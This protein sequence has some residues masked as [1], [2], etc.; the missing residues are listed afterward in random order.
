MTRLVKLKVT[1]DIKDQFFF[2]ELEFTT[3]V[4]FLREKKNIE[5]RASYCQN[6]YFKIKVDPSSS[7]P[8]RQIA[9][10][11]RQTFIAGKLQTASYRS[12]YFN[13]SS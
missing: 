12:L 13:L 7:C 4:I 6:I 2:S 3:K 11:P 1:C 5:K 8:N 9:K 10:T